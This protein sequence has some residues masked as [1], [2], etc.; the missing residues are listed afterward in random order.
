[1]EWRVF[2]PVPVEGSVNDPLS[3]EWTQRL[4]A[5]VVDLE[6]GMFASSDVESRDDDYIV[7]TRHVGLKFRHG[8]KL[9]IKF[10]RHIARNGA[11]QWAK[12]KFKKSP[13]VE[14]ISN[15]VEHLREQGYSN[16]DTARGQMEKEHTVTVSKSRVNILGTVNQNELEFARINVAFAPNVLPSEA[17]AP[18]I[19]SWVSVAV[20]GADDGDIQREVHE[21]PVLRRFLGVV[22]E[23]NNIS[24]Q[25]VD[26]QVRTNVC[27]ILGGYPLF[28][29]Y[30]TG[31]ATAA[32]LEESLLLIQQFA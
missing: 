14:Q 19:R 17:V 4:Q 25:H 28:V 21:N 26:E 20:E 15:V 5:A 12:R 31:Q 1:M 23:I 18:T 6:K 7:V 22:A 30:I 3:Q 11:E 10:L 29:Q 16:I 27:S 32:D 9:E 2:V 24:A 8:K 13:L